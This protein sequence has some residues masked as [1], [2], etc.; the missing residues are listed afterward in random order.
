M[1]LRINRNEDWATELCN[2]D[3][4]RV[5]ASKSYINTFLFNQFPD[6]PVWKSFSKFQAWM[7]TQPT[8]PANV[9]VARDA[10]MWTRRNRSRLKRNLIQ[11]ILLNPNS[12][13]AKAAIQAFRDSIPIV[14]VPR[15]SKPY[16]PPGHW[17][18]ESEE[19]KNIWKNHLQNGKQPDKRVPRRPMAM[20]N[21]S[22][23]QEN[24]T[25]SRSADFVDDKTG[26]P[27]LLIARELCAKESLVSWANGVVLG[28]VDL[29]RNIRKEDGGCLVLTGWSAGSRSRP[30]FDFARNFLRKQTEDQKKSIRYQA[31]LVFAL[32]WN[33]VRALGPVGAVQ[34]MENFLEESGIYRMDTGALYEDCKGAYTIEADGV[35]MRF[36][37]AHM[38]PPSG[39]MARN[40]CRVVHREKQPHR[41]AF[42]W[43]TYRA[44]PVIR[45]LRGKATKV[46]QGG[47]FYLASHGIRVESSS[48]YLAVWDPNLY[49][50]TSLQSIPYSEKRGPLIQS[51]LAIVTSPRLPGVFKKFLE[52]K[53]SEEELSKACRGEEDDA[54]VYTLGDDE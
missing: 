48:N 1:R 39:V 52:E 18:I 24:L 50:A 16:P 9:K 20:V 41:Y 10:A 28:N 26:E 49:H 31:A 34:D 33:L 23:L 53:I 12:P 46:Q 3:L 7:G 47:H 45:N 19:I 36:A 17:V 25:A 11:E 29:E 32:F 6:L 30:Q 14:R 22:K 35:P 4:P 15:L 43:T 5:P 38:A 42:S 27:I 2:P 54:V 13:S 44:P 8:L 51:G 40:Y 21:F 37:D